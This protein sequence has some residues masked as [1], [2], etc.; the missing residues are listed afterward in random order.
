MSLGD[1]NKKMSKSLG[2]NSYIAIRDDETTI[3]KKIKKAVTDEAGVKNLLELYSYFGKHKDYQKALDD[4]TD[5]KLMN[6]KLKDELS[7]AIIEFLKPVQTKIK[8]LEGNP[9]SVQKIL[10]DGEKK[11]Q[12][13]ADQ[14]MKQVRKKVGVDK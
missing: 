2:E 8:E 7:K 3:T 10:A 1:S 5:G 6:S 9:A 12:A 11:A 13:I 4:Y 14:T